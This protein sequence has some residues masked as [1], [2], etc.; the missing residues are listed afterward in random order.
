MSIALVLKEA[1][2]EAAI[3]IPSKAPIQPLKTGVNLGLSIIR[4]ERR[5]SDVG[6]VTTEGYSYK[7]A[8]KT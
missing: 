1:S 2:M 5:I 4:E 7:S 6:R 8:S 3:R